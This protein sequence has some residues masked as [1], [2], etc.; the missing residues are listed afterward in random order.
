MTARRMLLALALLTLASPGMGRA[1]ESIATFPAEFYSSSLEPVRDEEIARLPLLD[2]VLEEVYQSHDLEVVDT[3]PVADQVD[4]Y[5]YLWSCNNCEIGL[6]RKLGARFASVLWVQK[7]SNL[8]LNIN[9][10]ISD[11]ELGR[12]VAGGSVDI[13]GNNDV[14][15]TR[16]LRYLLE[17][18]IFPES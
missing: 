6:A 16:G 14:S 10:R 8:I 1:A 15:W 5:A 7:V 3:A 11:V 17:H 18:R 12:P 9:L 13:R 2:R 4:A